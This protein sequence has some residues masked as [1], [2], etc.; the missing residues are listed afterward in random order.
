MMPKVPSIILHSTLINIF[1]L[2]D[3]V[4]AIQRSERRRDLPLRSLVGHQ[5]PPNLFVLF[6]KDKRSNSMWS[7]TNETRYPASKHPPDSFCSVDAR[8]QLHNTFLFCCA[9]DPSLDHIHGTADCGCY[10][11]RCCTCGKVCCKI[12]FHPALLHKCD[13]NTVV[14]C[15]LTRCHEHGSETIGYDAS[16]GYFDTFFPRHADQSIDCVAVVSSFLG[17]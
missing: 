14:S 1:T 5:H 17:F 9:H 8:Q 16:K 11:S 2:I 15:K 13:L 10:E 6:Q 7:K 3:N 12:I 4:K